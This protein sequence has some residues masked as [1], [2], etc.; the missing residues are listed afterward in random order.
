MRCHPRHAYATNPHRLTYTLRFLIRDIRDIHTQ[1]QPTLPCSGALMAG[2]R[3]ADVLAPR[4]PAMERCRAA[5]PNPLDRVPCH[6]RLC[7]GQHPT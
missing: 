2:W 3:M 4:F 7:Y 1:L 5:T 6:P